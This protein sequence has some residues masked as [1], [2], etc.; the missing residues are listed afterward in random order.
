[1]HGTE[2]CA[3]YRNLTLFPGIEI[4]CKRTVSAEFRA[5][6]PKLCGNCTFAQN[7]H[8]NKLGE[9]LVFYAEE[10]FIFKHLYHLCQ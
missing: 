8:T 2:H 9:I 1:M 3:K 4:L 10:E 6:R 5:I 7:F